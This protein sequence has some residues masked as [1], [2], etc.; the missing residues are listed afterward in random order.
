MAGSRSRGRRL[1]V[2]AAEGAPEEAPSR[3]LSW[4]IHRITS[5]SGPNSIGAKLLKAVLELP[6]E[7]PPRR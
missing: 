7:P 3:S 2:P 5:A 6:V 1:R 4:M